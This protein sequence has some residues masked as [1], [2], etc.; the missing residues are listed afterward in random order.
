MIVQRFVPLT[1]SQTNEATSHATPGTI[2]SGQ[3]KVSD[4]DTRRIETPLDGVKQPARPVA[5]QTV[6][7]LGDG[8]GSL[9]T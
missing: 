8:R 3:V 2:P 7:I 9:Y 6:S 5:G 4:N 1:V